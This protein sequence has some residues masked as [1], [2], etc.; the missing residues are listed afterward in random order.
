MTRESNKHRHRSRTTKI[1]TKFGAMYLHIEYDDNARAVGGW[2]SDPGKEPAS[3]IT[4]LVEALS[5]GL[6][7]ALKP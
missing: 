4:Q 2:I 5:V 3:Q 7:Q 6:N 1:P